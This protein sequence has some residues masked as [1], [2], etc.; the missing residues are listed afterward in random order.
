MRHSTI[1]N[2]TQ[3]LHLTPK[4]KLVLT[5]LV[6]M[7]VVAC[8][9]LASARPAVPPAMAAEGI[10]P[11]TYQQIL[12]QPGDTLWDISSRI[13][14]ESDHTAVMEH[15]VAYNDLESSELQVGQT[16]FVPVDN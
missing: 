2:T 8:M 15:I 5:G 12:I 11:D 14:Q 7:L 4:G 6:L 9:L 16:L 13:A 1:H 3:K 10:Q